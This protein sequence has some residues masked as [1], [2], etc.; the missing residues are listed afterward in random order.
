MVGTDGRAVSVVLR[1]VT[2]DS[3][4][5]TGVLSVVMPCFN[6]E[7]TVEQILD[8]AHAATVGE[9]LRFLHAELVDVVEVE[10]GDSVRDV[11][12]W[13]PRFDDLDTIVKTSLAWERKIAAKDETAYWAD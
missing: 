5:T 4:P 8:R 6:E 1:A 2:V 12:G 9:A 11:L 7:Q 3:T 13:E 10:R